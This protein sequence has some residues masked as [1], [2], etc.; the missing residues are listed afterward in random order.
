MLLFGEDVIHFKRKVGKKI[1]L[2][3]EI[4]AYHLY[5]TLNILLL[6]GQWPRF[7]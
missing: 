4:M 6:T 7:H 5:A 3:C 2:Y 1:I